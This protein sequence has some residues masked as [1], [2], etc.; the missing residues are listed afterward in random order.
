MTRNQGLQE[1]RDVLLTQVDQ[2][3]DSASMGRVQKTTETQDVNFKEEAGRR[4]GP[5]IEPGKKQNTEAANKL[6]DEVACLANTPGGGAL[7]VGIEGKSGTIIGTELDIDWL[8]QNIYT[9]IDVAPD[10]SARTVAGQRVLVILVAAAR[11]PIPNTSGALRWR[12]GDSCRPVDR[13]EWWDYQRR[14]SGFDPMAQETTLTVKD[15]RHGALAIARKQQD[16]FQELSDEEI[17]RGIGAI[18]A[19]GHLTE[20]GRNVFT[21]AGRTLIELTIFDVPGG[22]VVNRVSGE[23]EFS[24]LEQLEQMESALRVVNGNS[25]VVE[26]LAHRSVPQV[27]H[28]AVRESM[29]NAMIHRDWNRTEIIE[30]R[31]Y[32]VDSTLEVRSPG[33]FM[34]AITTDNV[35]SNRAARYPALA[36]LYRAVGFVDKQGVGVD[37]MYQ[38]MIVLGH[39]PP[40]F[41]EV[42]GPFISVTLKG[43]KPVL[44]VM[45][46]VSAI[47]PEPRQRDYRIAIILYL[48]LNRP[49]VTVK[50]VAQEL[51]TS[52]ESAQIAIEAA[53][54][55]TV[56]GE[57]I[58]APHGPTWFLGESARTILE[59]VPEYLTTEPEVLR[60]VADLW[61]EEIGDLRTADLVALCGISRSTA[62]SFI[63]SLL[64]EGSIT[65]IGGGRSTRY[66]K[67]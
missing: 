21:S 5:N 9:R 12:V 22:N 40:I 17:L 51:Q 30:V 39:R 6:A 31:W 36:D 57:P 45:Q 67:A 47:V 25:T 64:S 24:A 42:E 48:L 28:S 61:F 38:S 62:K 7:I 15:A 65:A 46:L 27:P 29:L 8:R 26:G 32:A 63:D 49:F 58:I 14:Q 18:N 11:E 10:I 59:K 19:T 2:I 60:G 1:R 56:G 20:A 53:T 52:E 37:R 54:Q 3:L 44:P 23:P 50:T 43:G 41:E 66:R 16:Y 35:L 34:P 55:T 13:A 33:G 4:N